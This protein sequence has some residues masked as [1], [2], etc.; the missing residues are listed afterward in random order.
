MRS[1]QFR[2]QFAAEAASYIGNGISPVALSIGILRNHGTPATLGLVLAAGAV[3]AAMFVLAGGVWADR[4]PRN[5]LIASADTV[6]GLTQFAW[7]ALFFT[8]HL[9]LWLMI[10]VQIVAGT[11]M[12]FDA[13]ASTT[14]VTLTVPA[15]QLQE[16]NA[17]LSLA[18]SV[19]GTIGPLVAGAL[20]L[21]I[22]PGW[23]LGFDGLTFFASAMLLFRLRLPAMSGE[24][25]ERDFIAELRDGL[26]EVLSRTW[27]WTS[28]AVYMAT[29]FCF[30]ILLVLGPVIALQR[31]NG[32][33]I[34][35]GI[36][37]GDGLGEAIGGAL[38]L[39]LKAKRPMFCARLVELLLV[40]L[41]LLL[42]L[43]GLPWLLIAAAVAAGVSITYPFA[44]WYTATQQ[45]LPPAVISRVS[46]Y[47]WLGTLTFQPVGFAVAGGLAAWIGPAGALAGAGLLILVT[48]VGALCF[49]GVRRF[50]NVDDPPAEVGQ[51]AGSGQS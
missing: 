24:P 41:F 22:G 49:P 21:T 48:R 34:W 3:P 43:R 44:L 29:N 33:L 11:A 39:R 26:R 45:N 20:V 38:A 46:S 18:R 31:A 6:H 17:L 12:A 30:G 35:A 47:D 25:A 16:A 51:E 10:I 28:I 13:P 1:R 27:V 7:A 32:V 4:L 40:P 2:L 5:I 37:A 42:A 36:I 50:R 23:A 9:D 8:G 14:L 15:D 19:T